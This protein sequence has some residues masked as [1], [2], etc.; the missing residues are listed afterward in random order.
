[1]DATI[2]VFESK[3]KELQADA[4]ANAEKAMAE[5][6]ARR[7]AFSEVFEKHK[8]ESE[9]VWGRAMSD[10]NSEWNAFEVSFRKYADLAQGQAG[11]M[12]AAWRA[13][14]EA[15][16][17]A[18]HEAM[19]RLSRDAMAFA[20][21]RKGDVDAALERM[22][23]DAKSADEKLHRLRQAGT[24]SWSAAKQALEESRAAFDK[25]AQAAHEAIK[26]AM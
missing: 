9:A 22:K 25:A 23:S 1:M 20:A 3:M 19:E 16:M 7:E 5:M 24:E 18:W 26:R 8:A 12:E 4:R 13:R 14:A 2:A 10:M 17:K 21:G 15:Q 6:R 11:Q